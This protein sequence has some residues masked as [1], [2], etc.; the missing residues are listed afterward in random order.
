MNQEKVGKVIEKGRK[1]KKLTQEELAKKLNVSK[2]TVIKF[3]KGLKVPNYF[4]LIKLSDTLDISLNDLL[5]EEDQTIVKEDLNEEFIKR[6]FMLEWKIS[7]ISTFSFLLLIFVSTKSVIN[8]K[9]QGILMLCALIILLVGI[10]SAVFIEQ[11]TG[12]YECG[13]CKN[14]YI[15]KYFQVLFS[16]HFGKNRYLRCP[17]CDKVT[18]NKKVLNKKPQ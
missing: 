18:L 2:K 6:L 8:S 15:P 7:L 1:K 3:E 16:I 14:R 5:I 4:I 12:Y 11:K 10:L 9:S 17:K 13:D